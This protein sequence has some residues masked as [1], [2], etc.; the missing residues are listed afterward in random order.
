MGSSRGGA[1]WVITILGAS[2]AGFANLGDAIAAAPD[3]GVRGAPETT[4][5]A[6]V[7]AVAGASPAFCLFGANCQVFP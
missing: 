2:A 5:R 4:C 7:V 3:K 6:W 1:S